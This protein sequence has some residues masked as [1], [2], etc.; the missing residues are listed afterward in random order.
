[1]AGLGLEVDK[2]TGDVLENPS[3]SGFINRA[4]SGLVSGLGA[5]QLIDILNGNSSG[6]TIN[7]TP[8]QIA[9]INRPSGGR[10]T[11][12][13]KTP[14]VEMTPISTPPI[15][16]DPSWQLP[17]YGTIYGDPTRSEGM[18]F[19]PGG[20]GNPPVVHDTRGA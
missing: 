3:I 13:N 7:L 18:R 8:S 11:L 4:G 9:R 16:T 2:L 17:Y 19:R 15:L 5:N 20:R 12:E 6:S 14:A 10:A 1:M